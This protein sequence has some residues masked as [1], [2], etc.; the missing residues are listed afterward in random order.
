VYGKKIAGTY[1]DWANEILVPHQNV[2]HK[3]AEDYGQYPSAYKTLYG[4]LGGQFDELCSAEGDSA[5][6]GKDIV[7]NN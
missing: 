1:V 6:V 5:D 4:L 7:A 3:D 2:G